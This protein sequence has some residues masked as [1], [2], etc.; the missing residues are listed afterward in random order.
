MGS[1]VLQS[2]ADL[3]LHYLEILGA[4]HPLFEPTPV[5]GPTR[6]DNARD[7]AVGAV[8]RMIITKVEAV[9]LDQVRSF[10]LFIE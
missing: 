7:N 8:A 10:F 3:S 9:P 4:L 2:Q 1:L 5:G 6:R